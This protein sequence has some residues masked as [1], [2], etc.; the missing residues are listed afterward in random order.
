MI[1]FL[2]FDSRRGPGIFL[3]TTAYRTALGPTQPSIQWVPGAL[4]LGLKQPRREA[5]HSPPFSAEVKEY[6]D[7]YLHSSN[8]PPERGADFK[9][10]STGT[11]LTSASQ[12]VPQT[13]ASFAFKDVSK[14]SH[15]G[16]PDKWSPWFT[17]AVRKC[18]FVFLFWFATSKFNSFRSVTERD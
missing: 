12:I 1:G 10:K 9:N 15:V 16:S 4:S 14:V 18:C 11:N 5:D 8:T 7:L 17:G 13:C 3:F 6:V 2:G